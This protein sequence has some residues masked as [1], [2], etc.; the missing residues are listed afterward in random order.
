MLEKVS[1]FLRIPYEILTYILIETDYKTV[2]RFA[3]IN[4][5]WYH[6]ILTDNTLWKHIYMSI[7]RIIDVEK[8]WLETFIHKLQFPQS[9]LLKGKIS[10]NED[11]NTLWNNINWRLE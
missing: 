5:E 8:G 3:Q 2:I 9:H 4:R 10:P 1:C 7:Y 11:M 6:I